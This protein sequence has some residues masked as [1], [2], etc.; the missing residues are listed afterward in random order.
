MTYTWSF[1]P[2][3]SQE[4]KNYPI[5]QQDAI[6]DFT[7]VFEKFG[8]SDFSEYKGK[9]APSW[10]GLSTIDPVY[11][12]ARENNLWHYHIGI[13]NYKKSDYGDFFTSDW[14]LHFQLKN[15]GKE[16]LIV[17]VCYHYK[18]TGEFHLPTEE[19]LKDTE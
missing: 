8:L 7:D 18:S 5:D 17:D 19:Y 14:V 10:K 2:K 16:A 6:L 4:F 1:K 3:F 15:N 9:M 11:S 13:P 12:Y